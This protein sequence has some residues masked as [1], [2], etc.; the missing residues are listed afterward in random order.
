MT[1]GCSEG[2]V[3]VVLDG[4]LYLLCV[5]VCVF[6]PRNFSSVF[7]EFPGTRLD[8]EI[9]GNNGIDMPMAVYP[10]GDET[11]ASCANCMLVLRGGQ[12]ALQGRR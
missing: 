8:G 11:F 9:K 12:T 4:C 2:V 5:F 10:S 7:I 3:F 6:L 1:S